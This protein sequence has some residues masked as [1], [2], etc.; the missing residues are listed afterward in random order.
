MSKDKKEITEDESKGSILKAHCSSC[1]KITKQKVLQSIDENGSANSHNYPHDDF[2]WLDEYQIIQCQGCENIGFRHYHTDSEDY[3]V[4][5]G[6]E[7]IGTEK[8]YPRTNK[9]ARVKMEFFYLPQ[10]LESIYNE[11]LNS[12]NGNNHLLGAGGVRALVEGLCKERGIPGSKMVTGKDGSTHRRFKDLKEKINEL[13]QKGHLTQENADILHELR[14]M[15][16][17]ALHEL[18]P[19]TQ[20]DL[21]L[22]IE[23]MENTFT[24]V[25]ELPGKVKGLKAKRLKKESKSK[26]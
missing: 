12:L 21:I 7:V 1:E 10:Q 4:A 18:E 24:T 9:P 15:G 5:D 11:T 3:Y 25:Y 16:N 26:K 23:I 2:H 13:V 14:Y 17:S 6:G 19:P 20:D 8:I 22:G